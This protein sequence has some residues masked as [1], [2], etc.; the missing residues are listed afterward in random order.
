MESYVQVITTTD[1]K[2]DADRI[3]RSLV[4]A[5]LVACVQIIGPIESTYW[6]KANI[7][8]SREWLCLMKTKQNL[9][10]ETEKAIKAMHPYETPEIIAMPIVAGSSEYLEW[11]GN[12][13]KR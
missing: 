3:A 7:E 13:I 12:E 2:E 1:K 6:W 9:Y 8:T 5:R 10:D 4:E 11:L